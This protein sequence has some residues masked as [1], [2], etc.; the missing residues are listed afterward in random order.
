[1][2]LQPNLSAS[3]LF[4]RAM[5]AKEL[6]DVPPSFINEL[7]Y[8]NFQSMEVKSHSL[9]ILHHLALAPRPTI[10]KGKPKKPT[11]KKKEKK[12]EKGEMK[13]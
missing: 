12:K 10:Q 4:Q 2:H 13:Q 9:G 11:L 3:W 8:T 5:S 7:L 6:P 1:M